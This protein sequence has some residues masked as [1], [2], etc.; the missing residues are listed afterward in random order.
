MT[1]RWRGVPLPALLAAAG[2]DPDPR[3]VVVRSVTGWRVR[4]D[5][6]ELED[7][8][9]ASGVTDV[10]LPAA[11]GAPCRLVAPTRRGF[12]WVKWVAEVEVA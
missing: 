4:L 3:F 10:D 11:N 1:T 9:L 6:H 5:S 2:A 12:D 8:M 7:A